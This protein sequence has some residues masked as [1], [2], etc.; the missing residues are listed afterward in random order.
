MT[1]SPRS[2]RRVLVSVSS[3][4]VAALGVGVLA[5][6]RIASPEDAAARTAPPKASQITVPVE[7]RALSSKVVARGDASFDGAVNLRVETAGLGTPAVVTGKV[8]AVGATVTEGKAILEITGRPV[9]ALA[10][11][12]PMYRALRPGSRGPDVLQLEQVLR[13]LKFD[14]GAADGV[15]TSDTGSAVARLFRA[16]GYEAPEVDQ[17]YK[18]AV[19][20]AKQQVKSAQD[21][22]RNA[23]RTLKQAQAGP[24]EAQLVQANNEV[25]AAERELQAARGNAKA[26]AAAKDRLEL[27]KAQRRDLLKEKDLS[28]EKSALADAQERLTDA[29]D[30]LVKAQAE[31]GTPLPVSEVVY[32]KSLPRRVDKVNVSRGAV[33]NG[34]VMS[35]SGASLVVTLKVDAATKELLKGGMSASLDLG[36]G[37]LIPARVTR[38]TRSDD[39]WNVVISPKSL[40]GQQL[41]RLRSANVRV[42]IPVKSTQG[43][44]LAVPTSALS[45][46]PDGESR[47]EVLRNGKVE[48]VRVEVGLS[49]DGFAEIK[50][51][52][53]QLAEGDQVVVGK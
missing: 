40:T 46:G 48:L 31:A 24:T 14:P 51:V 39:G 50:P 35:V 27:A 32:V 36:D 33:V 11:A 23:K 30:A 12:L 37:K 5:G 6:S 41:E 47:V 49:A 16:A 17:Q 21:G 29:N 34:D 7:K 42:T 22:V 18:N 28:I 38:I 15:Y 25:E 19:D 4:A 10:G 53:G 43:K 45:A 8:P 26:Y 1:P 3:I 13:R 9:I 44:V 52:G 2:R 20:Q